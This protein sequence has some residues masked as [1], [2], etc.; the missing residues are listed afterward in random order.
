MLAERFALNK[1]NP[2]RL[3]KNLEGLGFGGKEMEVA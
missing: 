1:K 2:S 3:K